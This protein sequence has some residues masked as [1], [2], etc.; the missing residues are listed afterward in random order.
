MLHATV[1]F[2][3]SL[4]ARPPCKA[5][6]V[7]CCPD[8][9]D[10]RLAHETEPQTSSKLPDPVIWVWIAHRTA[11]SNSE[12][13]CRTQVTT[14]VPEGPPCTIIARFKCK[15]KVQGSIHGTLWTIFYCP[16]HLRYG[17]MSGGTK[18]PSSAEKWI[19]R[20]EGFIF[21]TSA[22]QVY[23]TA[24]FTVNSQSLVRVLSITC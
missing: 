10:C 6:A 8:G 1:S 14:V 15:V 13:C 7:G 24:E 4:H 21:A 17:G 23:V 11:N 18:V 2:V 9:T 12:W 20:K 5:F 19:Q 16:R 3:D 22:H